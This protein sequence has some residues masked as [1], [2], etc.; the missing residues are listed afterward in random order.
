MSI[1]NITDIYGR[2]KPQAD[3]SSGKIKSLSQ[4][5]LAASLSGMTP[6]PS[7]RRIWVQSILP[8]FSDQVAWYQIARLSYAQ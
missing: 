3:R 2:L 8:P 5:I 6:R 4:S 1:S 7:S